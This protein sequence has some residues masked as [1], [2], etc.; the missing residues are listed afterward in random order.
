[1]A[2]YLTKATQLGHVTLGILIPAIRHPVAKEP[3][4]LQTREFR[5]TS[6]YDISCL[7]SIIF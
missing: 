5:E 2:Q 6:P 1:M 3:I 7:S 4:R